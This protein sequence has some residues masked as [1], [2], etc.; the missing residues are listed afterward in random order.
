MTGSPEAGFTVTNAFNGKL[1]VQVT[2]VW[3]SYGIIEEPE[4]PVPFGLYR[5]IEGQAV[6]SSVFPRLQFLKKRKAGQ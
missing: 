6:G 2:K 3:Q 4:R 1:A 5:E